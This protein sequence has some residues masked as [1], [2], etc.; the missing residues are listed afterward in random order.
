M[1]RTATG[2]T[3]LYLLLAL[4]F[5]WPSLVTAEW[6]VK[7]AEGPEG[8]CVVESNR[9]P[10]WDGYQQSTAHFVVTP[11]SVA[12]VSASILDGGSSDIGLA[13]DD[14]GF[15]RMDRLERD[16]SALFDTK[17]ELVVAQ[18][19]AGKKV[20]VQLRFWPTWPA[21]GTHSATISLIGFTKAY[22]QLSGCR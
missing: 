1:P 6:T 2:P 4:A 22:G 19:K 5:G 12:V 10:V 17:Y 7:E 8:R 14:E 3:T 9:Q 20:R 18:F 16:K 13:V 21:T 11:R 15:I